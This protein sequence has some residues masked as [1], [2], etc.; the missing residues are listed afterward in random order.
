MDNANTQYNKEICKKVFEILID[1]G[2]QIDY[3]DEVFKIS[4]S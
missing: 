4:W 3:N 1:K 2:Y